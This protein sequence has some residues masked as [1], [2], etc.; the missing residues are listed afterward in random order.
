[1]SLAM[2]GELTELDAAAL[3]VHLERC[4]RCRAY[5]RTVSEVTKSL[6]SAPLEQPEIPVLVPHRSRVRVPLRAVQVG[7]AAAVIA[8]VGAT[9]AGLTTGGERAVSLTAANAIDGRA[10]GQPQTGSVSRITV[11]D[12]RR[13]LPRPLRVRIA[14]V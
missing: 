10:V 5:A 4:E 14:I 7:A 3:K 1:M 6:R 9:S 12:E 13:G 2:D 11:R 8:V